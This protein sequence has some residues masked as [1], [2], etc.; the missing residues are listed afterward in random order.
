MNEIEINPSEETSRAMLVEKLQEARGTTTYAATIFTFYLGINAVLFKVSFY[1]HSFEPNFEI[2]A[3]A[4]GTGIIY[5]VVCVFY[6]V[7]RNQMLSDINYLN[8]LLGNPLKNEQM[9][10]LKYTALSAGLFTI[11]CSLAWLILAKG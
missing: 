4:I 9:L 3:V 5:F 1:K 2:Q 7:A 10:P 6:W 8:K 11:C